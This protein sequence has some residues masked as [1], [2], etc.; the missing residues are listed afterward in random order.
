MDVLRQTSLTIANA[1]AWCTQVCAELPVVVVAS[2]LTNLSWAWTSMLRQ[3]SRQSESLWG[4]D[5]ADLLEDLDQLLGNG[6]VE[7]DV[8]RC[9]AQER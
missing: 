3:F 8:G 2:N 4:K 6:A 7:E 5:T 1:T 9:S